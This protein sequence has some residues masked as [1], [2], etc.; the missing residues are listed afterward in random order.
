MADKKGKNQAWTVIVKTGD[1]KGAGTDA[2]VFVAFYDEVGARCVS[3][4]SFQSPFEIPSCSFQLAFLAFCAFCVSNMNFNECPGFFSPICLFS[5]QIYT[6]MQTN[7]EQN[8]T[9][10]L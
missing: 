6:Q 9:E 5:G 1:H 3:L 8:R 4:T 10:N 7:T 2:N